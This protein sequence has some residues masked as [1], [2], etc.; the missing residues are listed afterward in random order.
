MVNANNG[1]QEDTNISRVYS[2][3]LDDLICV[4]D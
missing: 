1:K 4:V 3:F 2:E